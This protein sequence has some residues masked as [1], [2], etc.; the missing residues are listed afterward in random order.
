MIEFEY[1]Q[2]YTFLQKSTLYKL[3]EMYDNNAEILETDY[4][5]KSFADFVNYCIMKQLPTMQK[6][7]DNPTILYED[8]F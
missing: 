4:R 3:E 7:L 1:F 6:Q 8:N 2:Q 5:I